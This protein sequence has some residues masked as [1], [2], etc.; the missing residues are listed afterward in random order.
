MDN[1]I[2]LMCYKYT[3]SFISFRSQLFP[4]STKIVQQHYH[5]INSIKYYICNITTSRDHCAY[6]YSC[7]HSY[8][9]YFSNI[10]CCC[11]SLNQQY[12]SLSLSE[13]ASTPAPATVL[14][15]FALAPFIIDL[16]PSYLII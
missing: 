6:K 13:P 12:N 16:N 10:S 5:V 4:N 8:G 9:L 15:M 1:T 2:S 11:L 7:A 3:I 14:N